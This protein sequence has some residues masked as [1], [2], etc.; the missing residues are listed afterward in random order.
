M[1][2]EELARNNNFEACR[3]E[4][5]SI[6]REAAGNSQHSASLLKTAGEQARKLKTCLFCIINC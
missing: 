2:Q 5:M 1:E 4:W 6:M 3:D